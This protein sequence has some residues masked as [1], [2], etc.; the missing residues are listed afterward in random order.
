LTLSCKK[1]APR[2][3][4]GRQTVDK[5]VQVSLHNNQPQWVLVRIEAQ[6]S[7]EKQFAERMYAYHARLWLH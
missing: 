6:V 1:I 7:P 5:P 4:T 2:R 3:R